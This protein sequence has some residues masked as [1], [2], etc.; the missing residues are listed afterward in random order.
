M[1]SKKKKDKE[2]AIKIRPVA[3][4]GKDG[5]LILTEEQERLVICRKTYFSKERDHENVALIERGDKATAFLYY[6][7]SEDATFVQAKLVLS[8]QVSNWQG[9]R[10]VHTEEV[11]LSERDFNDYFILV[12]VGYH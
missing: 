7:E 8:V 1:A 10:K 2:V 9:D 6:E 5:E 4:L 11:V 3:L 12:P